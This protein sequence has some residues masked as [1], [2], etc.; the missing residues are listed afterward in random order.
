MLAT[1]QPI[2][3]FLAEFDRTQVAD[4]VRRYD[5]QRAELLRRFPV[6]HWPTMRLEEYALGHAGSEDSFCRWMEFKSTD[7]GSI[8][9]GSARKHIIYQR[10]DGTG[11]YFPKQFANEREAW[12]QL[13][14]EFVQA[15]R[16]AGERAWDRVDEL[17]ILASGPALTLKTL[18]LYFPTEILPV[19]ST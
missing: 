8:R 9:G 17:Q 15:I 13:R 18:H 2:E 5:V 1:P 4:A 14:T 11:W 6:D 3:A 19:N 7:V 12:E 10:K 16:W